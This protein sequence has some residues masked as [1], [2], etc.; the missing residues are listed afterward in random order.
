MHN[1]AIDIRT[2]AQLL[3]GQM[4]GRNRVSCPGPGHSKHDLSLS[5]TFT[6]DGFFTNSFAGDDFRECRNH[7]NAALGWTDE[8]RERPRPILVVPSSGDDLTRTAAALR[9]WESAVPI[10]GTLAETYL[11]SRGLAYDGPAL[12]FRYNDRTMVA[13][14]MDATSGAPT[15]IHRTYLDT[16]GRKLGRKML[17]RAGVVQ[18]Y[19]WEGGF[20]VGV[21]EGIET[22]LAADFRPMWSCLTEGG[23]SRLQ[24]L[25]WV[26]ALTIFADHD[27]NGVGQRA[28]LVCAERWHAA[29]KDVTVR[30]PEQ[31]GTDYADQRVAA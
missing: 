3:G 31:V 9:Y 13:L 25:P 27:E 6:H 17:G 2:A 29:G 19:D 1:Q 4:V 24:V 28:A 10:A 16:E 14:M 12:R 8:P 5:V 22:A 11:A 20:G 15:G 23:I 26:E 7:V 30:W 21:A 18:L